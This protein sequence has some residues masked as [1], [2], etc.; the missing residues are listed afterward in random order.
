MLDFSRE[1]L[2]SVDS[3]KSICESFMNS[4]LTNK[5]Q[6]KPE[7]VVRTVLKNY[8]HQN[9]QK[10]KELIQN[11]LEHSPF[12]TYRKY[13]KYRHVQMAISKNK[14]D[15][16]LKEKNVKCY[17]YFKTILLNNCFDNLSLEQ[18]YRLTILPIHMVNNFTVSEGNE[19]NSDCHMYHSDFIGEFFKEL[20][21]C[22]LSVHQGPCSSGN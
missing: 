16:V 12:G 6:L 3:C 20:L 9:I 19:F 1:D 7:Y 15:K 10:E 11:L 22:R 18:K 4:N 8:V 17:F 2:K 21:A 14:F 13:Q 5:K